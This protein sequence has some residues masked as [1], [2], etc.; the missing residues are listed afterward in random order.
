MKQHHYYIYIT[1]NPAFTVL[2]TGVTNNLE[3]RIYE[4]YMNRGKD[5]SFAGKFH[6]YNLLY[7]ER[8]QYINNAIER[9]K[10]IKGWVKRKKLALIKSENPRLNF[11][12]KELFGQWPPGTD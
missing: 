10:E 4:H 5:N 11:L 2:Y 8:Y 3:G 12:N 6:C 7:Y 1:T 9:E